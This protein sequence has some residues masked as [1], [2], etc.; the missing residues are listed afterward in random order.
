MRHSRSRRASARQRRDAQDR[1]HGGIA[2]REEAEAREEGSEPEYHDH[3]Q[4]GLDRVARLLPE[5]EPTGVQHG[6]DDLK[7]LRPERALDIVLWREGADAPWM[8]STAGV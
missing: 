8:P 2:G 5:H 4:R 1:D 7:R 6:A 3:E